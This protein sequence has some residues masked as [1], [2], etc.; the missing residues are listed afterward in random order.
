MSHRKFVRA[1][2]LKSVLGLTSKQ[3]TKWLRDHGVC[4]HNKAGVHMVA[5]RCLATK[6]GLLTQVDR[7]VEKSRASA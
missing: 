2:V 4:I 6:P 1:D 3:F 7:A 5:R